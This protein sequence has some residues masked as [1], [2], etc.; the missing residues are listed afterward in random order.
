MAI[1][2]WIK[3]NPLACSKALVALATGGATAYFTLV[4]KPDQITPAT[5]YLNSLIGVF[6]TALTVAASLASMIHFS[7]GPAPTPATRA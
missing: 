2:T 1:L 4:G 6:G 7:R 3:L 5:A